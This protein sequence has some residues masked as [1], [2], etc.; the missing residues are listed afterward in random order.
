[1]KAS[2]VERFNRTLKSSMYKYF[3]AEN[4]LRYIHII[5]SLVNACNNSKH[6]GIG[7]TPAQVRKND[8]LII[9]QRLYGSKLKRTSSRKYKYNNGD[10]VRISKVDVRLRKVIYHH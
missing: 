7:M 4:T 5:K 3:T 2:I 1:M 9:R 10:I 8:E 6:R